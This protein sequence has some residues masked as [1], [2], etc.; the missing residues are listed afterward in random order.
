[1]TIAITDACIFI[2]L[3]DLEITAEFFELNL[4]IHTTIEVW[5]EIVHEQQSILQTYRSV[6]KLTIHILEPEDFEK[7][8]T[9]AFPRALSEPDKSVVYMAGKLGAILLTSDGPVRKFAEKRAID[10]HGMLWILDELVGKSILSK[11]SAHKKLDQ[12]TTNNLMY[13]NNIKLQM[14]IKKRLNNWRT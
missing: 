14:E 5:N 11:S 8:E 3:L 9:F 1:M 4:D 6:G 2:D 12:L 10:R 13:I 7:M